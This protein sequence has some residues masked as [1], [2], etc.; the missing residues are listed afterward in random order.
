MFNVSE[1]FLVCIKVSE[2]FNLQPIMY[3]NVKSSE[4]NWKM[5]YVL[6]PRQNPSKQ[7]KKKKKKWKTRKNKSNTKNNNGKGGICN[8]QEVWRNRQRYDHFLVNSFYYF[9][10][11]LS[12]VSSNFLSVFRV[13]RLLEYGGNSCFSHV[14][15]PVSKTLEIQKKVDYYI[16]L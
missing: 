7:E 8:T 3:M 13:R 16:L 2:I 10:F 14:L 4:N 15:M 6:N 11:I 5:F 12:S 1:L 9:T